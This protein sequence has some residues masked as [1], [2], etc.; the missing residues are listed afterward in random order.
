MPP[1][2]VFFKDNGTERIFLSW[3]TF[4]TPSPLQKLVVRH[5]FLTVTMHKTVIVLLQSSLTI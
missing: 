2:E 3:N 1:G 5:L 4:P